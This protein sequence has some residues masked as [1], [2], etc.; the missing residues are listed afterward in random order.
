VLG[1]RAPVRYDVDRGGPPWNRLIVVTVLADRPVRVGELVLVVRGGNV[2][3]QQVSD[4]EVLARWAELDLTGPV[5][6][7]VPR[8]HRAGPYWLRCFTSDDGIDLADPPVR[9][10]K[11]T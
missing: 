8:P 1:A 7:S 3:P 11:V 5:E 10:L 4:G 6:L 9:R 2:M